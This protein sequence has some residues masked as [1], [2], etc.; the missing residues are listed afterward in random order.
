MGCFLDRDGT[1]TEEVGYVNHPS[2]LNLLPGAAEGIA[3]LNR[4]GVPV[5]LATNQAGV[6]RGYF[7]EDLVKLVLDRLAAL[8]SAQGARLDGMYYCPH[9]PSVGPPPYRQACDCRKPRPGMLERGAADFG[10][11]LGRCYVVGDKISDVYFRPLGGSQGRPRAH[12]VRLGRA[13]LP[14]PGLAGTARF[15]RRGPRAGGGLDPRG[16]RGKAVRQ[17][18]SGERGAGSGYTADLPPCFPNP[19]LPFLGGFLS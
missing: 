14:A 12:G 13:Y 10:L 9:H 16:R 15:H 19:Q 18:G 8:L 7:T 6:A 17:S 2:R 4:A 3:M 1:V 11:D 5:L